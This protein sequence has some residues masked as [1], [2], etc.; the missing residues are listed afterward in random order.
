MTSE[1]IPKKII[2]TTVGLQ[3]IKKSGMEDLGKK[4]E[5]IQSYQF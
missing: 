2:F 1:K 5:K 4:S 3:T